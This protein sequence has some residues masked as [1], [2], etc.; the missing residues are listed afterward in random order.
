MKKVMFFILGVVIASYCFGDYMGRV[1]SNTVKA[2]WVGPSAKNSVILKGEKA[3]EWITYYSGTG[4]FFTW[5]PERATF[6][7]MSDFSQVQYPFWI[8]KVKSIFY[9]DGGN[10]WIS[11]QFR[12]K[13]YAGDGQTVLYESVDLTA[14]NYPSETMHDLPDSIKIESGDFWLSVVPGD[15]P[16]GSPFC[17]SDDAFQGHSFYDSSGVWLPNS[18][19]GEHAKFAY[20][21]WTS[22]DH[23]VCVFSTEAP[24]GGVYVGTSYE[25]KATAKN[26]GLN[27]E[28]FKVG[29]I[30]TDHLGTLVYADSQTVNDLASGATQPLTFVNWTPLLYNEEHTVTFATS[31]AGDEVPDNDTLSRVSQSYEHGEIAYDDFKKEG[32]W[33]VNT[34]NGA[35]DAFAARFT[36]YVVPPFY[37]T[38]GKVYV[39]STKALEYIGLF[40]GSASTPDMGSPYQTI[41]GPLAFASPEWIVVDFDSTLTQI[42]TTD[43][44]WLV[45][46]FAENDTGPA[47][48]SDENS[49]VD[50][51][52]YWSDDLSVWEVVAAHDFMMRIVHVP[53]YGVEESSVKPSF[54]VDYSNP[55]QTSG[56]ILY[57]L[58][59]KAH[60]SIKLYD[61]TGRLVTTLLDQ[62]RTEG[63][64]ELKLDIKELVSGIY[65]C[66]FEIGEETGTKKLILLK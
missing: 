39:N 23:D 25:V 46:K 9:K 60:V 19:Y 33:A 16:S 15:V 12:F 26:T 51:R 8:K 6:F 18:S 4:A 7:E 45:A 21:S 41:T 28:T 37:V 2:G 14:L 53:A 58:P 48:G 64:H 22:V 62:V 57:E 36:S 24:S 55:I 56:S 44:I 13:I 65:F 47:I 1:I 66:K 54:K 49:P 31:L 35:D 20:V 32:W 40:P 42:T 29:C 43:D 11:D 63:K 61:I 17:I 3:E 59:T 34:P 5:T 52:S 10:P 38:K 30:I 27:T 50:N